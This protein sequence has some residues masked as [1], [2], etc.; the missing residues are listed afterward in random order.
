MLNHKRGKLPMPRILVRSLRL[1][2][3]VAAFAVTLIVVSTLSLGDLR[4]VTSVDASVPYETGQSFSAV[5][6]ASSYVPTNDDGTPNPNGIEVAMPDAYMKFAMRP[7]WASNIP[8][9]WSCYKNQTYTV[10]LYYYNGGAQPASVLNVPVLEVGPWNQDDGYVMPEA[11]SSNGSVRRAPGDPGSTNGGSPSCWTTQTGYPLNDWHQ[12]PAGVSEAEVAY[13]FNFNEQT[14]TL[15]Q[16]QFC[17]NV[18]TP[19]PNNLNGAGIDLSTSVMNLLTGTPRNVVPVRV[20]F[21]WQTGLTTR[22][23][24]NN[25]TRS[26]LPCEQQTNF[27]VAFDWGASGACGVSSFAVKW[28]NRFSWARAGTSFYCFYIVSN[29]EARLFIGGKPDPARP[30][31]VWEDGSQ[32][33]IGLVTGSSPG[34]SWSCVPL[35]ASLSYNLK[36]LHVATSSTAEAWLTGQPW[37]I[38]GVRVFMVNE[39]YPNR[40]LAN[41]APCVTY[42]L[43]TWPSFTGSPAQCS[44]VPGTWPPQ[45]FPAGNWSSRHLGLGYA[46]T[47][48]TAMYNFTV[49][50]Q[51]GVRLYVDNTL[52]V[53]AWSDGLHT[54]TVPAALAQGFHSIRIEHYVG[55][56]GGSL[57]QF[58]TDLQGDTHIP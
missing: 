45:P 24:W 7:G 23:G 54:T 38:N 27:Y 17:R 28:T 16:D 15:G 8:T 46:P 52:L 32:Q 13:S 10:D 33:V 40:S 3:R 51:D 20:V 9:Q 30:W 2:R 14:T 18:N 37:D 1:S 12:L 34:Q 56:N 21:K 35:Y 58:T 25:P 55:A 50:S 22:E 39:F 19:P 6:R 26:G 57:L 4:N 36:L 44:S 11:C 31:E 29:D 42:S 53:D 41:A 47:A 5:V 48:G 43:A 49:T